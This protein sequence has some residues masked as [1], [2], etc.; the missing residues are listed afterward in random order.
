MK[1]QSTDQFLDQVRNE[2]RGQHRITNFVREHAE[3]LAVAEMLTA[4]VTY[5]GDIQ[6]TISADRELTSQLRA[7][8]AKTY[9]LD[10]S[11]WRKE[12]GT[13]GATYQN[14]AVVDDVEGSYTIM[15]FVR[16]PLPPTCHLEYV[17]VESPARTYKKAIVKCEEVES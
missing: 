17:E 2:I 16:S 3:L 5:A 4:Y 9:E 13:Y 7:R 10:E 8:F 15:L 12:M 6:I 14:R 1:Y 11:V